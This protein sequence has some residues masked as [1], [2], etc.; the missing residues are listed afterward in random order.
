MGVMTF[1]HR[2]G[3]LAALLC[4]AAL[5]LGVASSESEEG[6][7]PDP[8][9]IIIKSGVALAEEEETSPPTDLPPIIIKSGVRAAC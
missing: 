9:P 4:T 5:P 6:I 8:P 1:T 2:A 7:P 3:V